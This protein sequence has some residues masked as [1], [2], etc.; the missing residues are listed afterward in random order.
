ME[1]HSGGF[2]SGALKNGSR[3]PDLR[4]L[5]RRRAQKTHSFLS[6]DLRRR[7]ESLLHR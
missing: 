5:A 6:A 3:A 1:K 7:R 2:I 4:H